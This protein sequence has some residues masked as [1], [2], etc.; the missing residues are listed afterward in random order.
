MSADISAM[1]REVNKRAR[2]VTIERLRLQRIALDSRE[3]I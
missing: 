1:A 2:E 3:P